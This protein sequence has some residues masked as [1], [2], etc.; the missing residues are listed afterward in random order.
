MVNLP[1]SL[2]KLYSEPRCGI[3]F[4]GTLW[5]SV[6]TGVREISAYSL[7]WSNNFYSK[8]TWKITLDGFALSFFII[9]QNEK[10]AILIT[11]GSRQMTGGYF[12]VKG[13]WGCAAEWGCIF[14]GWL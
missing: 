6:R 4:V 13:Y 7:F 14:M 8:L 3:H 1:S 12:L 2:R 9:E 11:L 5:K 10:V